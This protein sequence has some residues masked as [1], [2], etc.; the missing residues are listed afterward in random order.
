MKALTVYEPWATL[1]ALGA[2]TYETRSWDPASKGLKT[3]TLLAIHAAKHWDADTAGI[4]LCRPFREAL[5]EAGFDI[6]QMPSDCHARMLFRKR[7]C[8]FT[9]GAII[10]VG[11]LVDARPTGTPS[12]GGST[13]EHMEPWVE[14]LSFRERVFG[15]FS[16]GRWGLRMADVVRLPTPIPCDGMQGPWHLPD[17]VERAVW[18][19]LD[20]RD[21]HFRHGSRTHAA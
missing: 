12:R 18:A 1:L 5:A 10:G 2:K 3:P 9:L 13:E 15:D 20:N 4:L 16:P 8:P 21:L 11:L 19:Q 6:P 7:D 17:D 14:R